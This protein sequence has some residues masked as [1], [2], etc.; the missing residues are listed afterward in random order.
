MDKVEKIVLV[1]GGVASASAAHELR[2]LGYD[3]RLTLPTRELDSPYHRPPI[4][5]QLLTGQADSSIDYHE[6]SWWIENDVELLTRSAV[7]SLDTVARTATLLNKT[8]LEF[9]KALVATGAMVRRLTIP[10]AALTG[11]HYLRTPANAEAVLKDAAGAQSIVL[12]GGSFIAVEVAASLANLGHHCTMMM[13]EAH[14]FERTFGAAVAAHVESLLR[15]HGIDVIGSVDVE[16]FLGDG[17][18]TGVRT[19][20]GLLIPADLVVVGAGAVPDT[21]LAVKA[22]LAIGTSGGVLCD[23]RLLTSSPDVFAAGDMCEYDSV[24]HGRSLRVE[25]EAHAIAQGV[26][27]ARNMLGKPQDHLEVPYFWT[28]IADWATLEYVGPAR[29]WDEEL[30]TGS[31]DDNDFT[32]WYLE[33][34]HL[35]AALTCGRPDDLNIARSLIDVRTVRPYGDKKLIARD[36]RQ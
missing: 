29:T 33:N 4:T 21:K 17:H 6:S 13:Q 3:G 1:G 31:I 34:Q 32:V 36:S 22:G 26:T 12:V 7:M 2:R 10:G 24:I 5:K 18:V 25:H 28:D 30:V 16:E 20:S 15:S 8:V 14:C 11:V 19:S 27:A 35:V 23:S 9:D